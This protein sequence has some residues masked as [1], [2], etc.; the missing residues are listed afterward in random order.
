MTFVNI[1]NSIRL[2]YVVEQ[3]NVEYFVRL[4]ALVLQ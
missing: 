3:E 4:F 1:F 2:K